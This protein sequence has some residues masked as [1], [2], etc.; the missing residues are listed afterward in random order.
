MR[1]VRLCR[2]TIS[3]LG[4]PLGSAIGGALLGGIGAPGVVVAIACSY[5][6]LALLPLLAPAL[7]SL[8]VVAGRVPEHRRGT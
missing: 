8:A 1:C 5:L 7:R 2:A 4:F 6:A 3:S